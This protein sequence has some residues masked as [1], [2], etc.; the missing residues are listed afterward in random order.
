MQLGLPGGSC[1]INNIANTFTVDPGYPV[2]DGSYFFGTNMNSIVYIGDD[3]GV[4]S[5][6]FGIGFTGNAYVDDLRVDAGKTIND[7]NSV[8]AAFVNDDGTGTVTN[9][10]IFY[11]LGLIPE[12]GEW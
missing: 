6:G 4:D 12:G 8:A 9:L 5:T 10:N 7:L 3:F 1:N 11:A 2:N